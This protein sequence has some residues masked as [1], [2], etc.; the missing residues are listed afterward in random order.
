MTEKPSVGID[1]IALNRLTDPDKLAEFVLSDREKAEYKER[2]DRIEYLGGRFAA[3]EA[4][5]KAVGKGLGGIS[6]KSIE[7]LTGKNGEPLLTCEGK[8]ASVSIS[9]DGGFAVA[10]VIL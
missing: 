4:Y 7:I 2:S 3:K 9:H 1:L 5:L 8:A 10:I 6:L